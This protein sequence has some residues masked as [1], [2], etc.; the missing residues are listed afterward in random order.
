MPSTHTIA[1]RPRERVERP[2]PPNPVA[3]RAEQ[4]WIFTEEELLHTPSIEDGMSPA[5]ERELRR[6]GMNFIVQV[7]VM[8]KLPQLTLSTAGVFL[9]RFITRRSL[10]N[11]DGHKALHHYQIAATSLFLATKVEENC[12]KMKEL[13]IACCRVAQKNPNLLVDEQTKDFWRW[14]DT[15]LYHEDVLLE[16]IC[17]DLT[18]ESPYK[19]LFDML[20]FFGMEHNKRVRN[21]AWTFINDSHATQLCLLFTSRTIAAAAL[22]CGARL[23]DVSFPDEDGRPWWETQYVKLK[24]MRRACNY[25]ASIYEKAPVKEGMENIYTPMSPAASSVSVEPTGSDQ[26]VKRS[27][28][29]HVKGDDD[30]AANGEK[31]RHAQPETTR[32]DDAVAEGEPGPKRLKTGSN[33]GST[34]GEP[35]PKHHQAESN[36]A[37]VERT[38]GSAEA[39][40][41]TAVADD[42]LSEEGEVEE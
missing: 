34:E 18:I 33:G 26:G 22:Y 6:K 15:I 9:H 2:R 21:A 1:T 23:C 41:K 20:K 39:T 29:E 17:F 25:M 38:Q 37:S 3:A 10:V 7:G 19:L 16:T 8:L 36:G 32:K 24:D 42:D 35:G 4:Q 5:D 40:K 28:E 27:R 12:R 11:K 13:V 30:S 31:E 14:R